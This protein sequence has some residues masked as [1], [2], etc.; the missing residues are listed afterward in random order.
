MEIVFSEAMGTAKKMRK[1]KPRTVKQ[2][3]AG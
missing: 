2:D 3:G 1:N